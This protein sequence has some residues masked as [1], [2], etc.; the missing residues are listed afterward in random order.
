MQKN[1]ILPVIVD[2]MDIIIGKS[3][4]KLP[5]KLPLFGNI[6]CRGIQEMAEDINNQLI[7]GVQFGMKID[8][9]EDN[10][11]AHYREVNKLKK[12]FFVK[13]DAYLFMFGYNGV[14]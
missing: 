10:K 8:E 1:L 11:D 3:A 7:E 12:S 2:K 6:I 13:N 5:L 4:G 14:L 9:A